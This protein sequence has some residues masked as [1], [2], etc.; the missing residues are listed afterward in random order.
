MADD[1]LHEL[2]PE[3]SD[4][5]AL[6]ERYLGSRRITAAQADV[7]LNELSAGSAPLS[8]APVSIPA[9][10]RASSV[11]A[12]DLRAGRRSYNTPFPQGLVGADQVPE[13]NSGRGLRTPL[14]GF[15]QA[16]KHGSAPAAASLPPPPSV[17]SPPSA[18]AAWLPAPEESSVVPMARTPVPAALTPVPAAFPVSSMPPPAAMSS[19][20]LAASERADR[21]DS[22]EIL[23]D[24]EM[25]E[26]EADDLLIEDVSDDEA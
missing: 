10:S 26:L 16:V 7:L 5:E 25:L 19:P 9:P 21:E 4:I 23:V 13:L 22:F 12:P 3:P 17:F 24:D 18:S 20:P 2:G 11:P 14:P 15:L 6:I 8:P 1:N